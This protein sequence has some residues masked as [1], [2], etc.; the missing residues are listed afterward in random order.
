MITIAQAFAQAKRE[1]RAALIP[2]IMT[3]FPEPGATEQVA[4]ALARGGADLFEVGMPFSDPLADGPT[5]QRAGVRSLEHGTTVA[6]CIETAGRV[7]ERTK[8]PVI[9]F[10][11]VN[12]VLL[13]GVERFCRDAQHAGVQGLI[14]PDLPPEEAE[15]VRRTAREYGIDLIFLVAPTSTEDRLAKAAAVADGFLYC[16]SLTGVTGAR[17]SVSDGLA[18]FLARVRRHTDLPLAVGFGISTPEH[19]RLVGEVADGVAVGSALVDLLD[20]T[21]SATRAQVVE[22]YMRSLRAAAG[23][24]EPATA[25]A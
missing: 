10:G 1:G 6:A 11:Y 5:I 24:G 8:K 9:L 15:D 21:E 4:E 3:N 16:V 2:Y 12:P 14:L 13:Y 17:A 19:V 23:K 22:E 20:R 18:P 7:A 25:S